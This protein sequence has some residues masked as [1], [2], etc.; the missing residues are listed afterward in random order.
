M[1][2]I[3]ESFTDVNGTE[4]FENG[5]WELQSGND[6]LREGGED[7]PDLE[8][9][10]EVEGVN[11]AD[12]DAP[13]ES[14]LSQSDEDEAPSEERQV[15]LGCRMVQLYFAPEIVVFHVLFNEVMYLSNIIQYTSISGV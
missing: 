6:T 1:S 7:K 12:E 9:R 13:S 2:T 10:S 15:R 14:S 11:N 4:Q 5:T 8:E 3:L